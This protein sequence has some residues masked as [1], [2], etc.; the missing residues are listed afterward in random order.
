MEEFATPIN[1]LKRVLELSRLDNKKSGY[2][3]QPDFL[4]ILKPLLTL[5]KNAVINFSFRKTE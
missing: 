3:L 4:I 5:P 2:K 1:Q